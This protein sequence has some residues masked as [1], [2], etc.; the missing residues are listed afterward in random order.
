[1]PDQLTIGQP[2]RGVFTYDGYEPYG[3]TTP[4]FDG[5]GTLS[6]RATQPLPVVTPLGKWPDL[7]E[8]SIQRTFTHA[9]T[10]EV[11]TI[12]LVLTLARDAGPIRIRVFG[13]DS[14][15]TSGTVGGS[16]IMAPP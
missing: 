13:Q 12:D 10:R 6:V 3:E 7:C 5:I 15:V 11:T 8:V 16:P 14:L 1:M 9:V 4:A 2:I